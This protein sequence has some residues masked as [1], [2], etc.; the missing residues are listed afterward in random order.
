MGAGVWC[1][2]VQPQGELFVRRAGLVVCGGGTLYLGSS[3]AL[4]IIY[5]EQFSQYIELDYC[6]EP[7]IHPRS[8]QLAPVL[9]P[10]CLAQTHSAAY[11]S[12]L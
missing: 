9:S 6:P 8:H 11:V 5:N 12:G 4:S 3:R 2:Q 10:V 1:T 7:T